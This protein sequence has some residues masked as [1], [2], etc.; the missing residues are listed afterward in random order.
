VRWQGVVEKRAKANPYGVIY[1]EEVLNPGYK[2]ESR[3]GIHSSFVWGHGWLIQADAMSQYYLHKYLPQMFGAEPLLNTVNFMLGCHPATNES[4]VS[5]VGA[6]STL[7]AYGYNRA[8]W[9]NVP[10]GVISGTS[11]IKPNVLELKTFPFL[12]YQTEY[13]IHGGAIYIF[14]VLAAQ[15]LMR[16]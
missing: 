13:V 3:T 2:L 15:H 1:P 7:A 11:L 5:G 9:A 16:K 10:G 14:D 12:W 8:D 6:H 4:F